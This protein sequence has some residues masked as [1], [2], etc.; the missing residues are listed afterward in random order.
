MTKYVLVIDN[1]FIIMENSTNKIVY[2]S[3]LKYR[4]SEDLVQNMIIRV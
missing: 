3:T 2:K 1:N 4:N